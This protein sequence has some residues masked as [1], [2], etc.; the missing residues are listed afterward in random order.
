MTSFFLRRLLAAVP[1]LVG[2]TALAFAIL[3]F[4]PSDPLIAWSP[5]GATASAEALARLRAELRVDRGPV[6]RYLDWGL[7]LTRGDLGTSLRDG[8]PVGRV[9]AD[10]LPWT[11]LLNL[12]ALLMIYALAVPFGLLGAAAPGSSLDRLGSRVLLAVYALP[13]FA[14]ALLLQE[15]VE[16]GRAHV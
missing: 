13:S 7:A 14:A 5:G 16:I 3:N 8:R 9:L 11:V 2:I 4:L 1:T 6:E 10:A 12:C 15:F